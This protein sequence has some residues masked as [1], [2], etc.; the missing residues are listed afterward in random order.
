MVL[1]Q[2]YGRMVREVEVVEQESSLLSSSTSLQRTLLT[3]KQQTLS[4]H[5]EQCGLLIQG[6]PWGWVVAGNAK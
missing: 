6:H 1:P 3:R 2:A 5:P 4:I